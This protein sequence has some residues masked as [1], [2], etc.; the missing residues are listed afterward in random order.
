M[1][2]LRRTI[3]PHQQRMLDYALPRSHIA[4]YCEMRLGKSLVTIRWAQQRKLPFV[5]VLAPATVLPSWHEE[6]VLEGVDPGHIYTRTLPPPGTLSSGWYLW[7][8]E[9]ARARPTILRAPWSALVCDESTKL[10]NPKAQI[11]QLLIKQTD[12]IPNKAILSGLPAPE[13][14]LDYFEQFHFLRG[15]FMGYYN[16]YAFRKTFFISDAQGWDWYPTSGTVV[17][18]KEHVHRYAHVLTRKEAGI[19]SRK[20]YTRRVVEMTP[21]QKKAY[22]KAERDFALELANG[23]D[24]LTAYII[25]K[26]LWMS[27]IAGGFSSEAD[28]T[29]YSYAKVDELGELL[30]GEL[31]KESVVVWF[32]FNREI[33]EVKIRLA[34]K[35]SAMEITGATPLDTRAARLKLFQ[36]GHARILLAQVKCAKFGLDCSKASTAIYFSN[37]YDYEDRAQSEDRIVHPQKN[38][39]LLYIDLV[40]KGTI[41]E[42][43]SALLR[44]K[45]G[46]SRVFMIKLMERWKTQ[47]SPSRAV[48]R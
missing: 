40:T 30:L 39:P 41:D 10:R 23:E 36:S 2:Q 45:Y 21:P 29:T 16:Y 48:V 17:A 38:D 5:L 27:R 6:L 3:L 11:T 31:R 22:K 47:Y 7:N 42:D 43:I 8:Y 28:A 46:N 19:G 12:H 9:L 32:R 13:S 4:L 15:M 35:F 25:T 20:I 44:E 1:R 37:S 24:K 26:I 18:I 14:P 33:E 34:G